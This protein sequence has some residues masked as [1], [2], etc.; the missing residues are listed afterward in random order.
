M[1]RISCLILRIG[2]S[3]GSSC[4]RTNFIRFWCKTFT[5][6]SVWPDVLIGLMATIAQNFGWGGRSRHYCELWIANIFLAYY[7]H[8]RAADCGDSLIITSM[9]STMWD[10][11]SHGFNWQ[12]S[13][14]YLKWGQLIA[15]TVANLLPRRL[16]FSRIFFVYLPQLP[17]YLTTRFLFN[18]LLCTSMLKISS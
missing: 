11:E 4:D 7:V 8:L 10:G 15:V 1:S 5:S 13:T 18:P 2:L 6:I 3:F 9:F 17:A 16:D 14:S 12:A